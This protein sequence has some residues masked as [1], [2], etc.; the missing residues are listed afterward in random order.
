MKLKTIKIPTETYHFNKGQVV[1]LIEIFKGEAFVKGKIRGT[2]RYTGIRIPISSPKV[3]E[4]KV[5]KNF[6]DFIIKGCI[7]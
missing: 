6:Y 4:V 5:D 3:T 2:G 7:A 1:Y